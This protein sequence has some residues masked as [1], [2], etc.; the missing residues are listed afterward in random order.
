M[1]NF[2][3]TFFSAPRLILAGIVLATLFLM[4][5]AS[6][7]D[8]AIMDELAHIPA[9]YGY[10]HNLDYRLNPEHPPLI[11]ALAGFPLLF[12]DLKFPTQNSAWT[13][14]VNGQWTMGGEF[15]YGSGHDPD[16]ILRV[17][18]MGPILLTLF[19]IMLIYFWSRE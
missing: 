12:L 2:K 11:K 7:G 18:R 5:W 3:Y 19:L 8:S 15:L 14:D 13:T 17:A 4:L 1:Q 10:V 16:T 9:G 6:F